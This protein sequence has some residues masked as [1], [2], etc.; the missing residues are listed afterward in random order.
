MKQKETY[1]AYIRKQE[2][3]NEMMT[4]VPCVPEE[5]EK[6]VED[7][8]F[9]GNILFFK[10][11]ENRTTFNCT[12]LRLCRLEKK[13]MEARRKNHMPEMQ[14]TGNDKQQTGGKD[15]QSHGNHSTA[16]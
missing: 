7:K 2:R 8:L 3:I 9:P 13:R 10:K 12:C 16:I 11:E 6:W 1:T 15:S 5:A 14:G 4:E